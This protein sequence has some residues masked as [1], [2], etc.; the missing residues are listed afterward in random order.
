MFNSYPYTNFHEL[1][2]AYFLQQFAQIFQQWNELYTTLQEWKVTT[3]EELETWKDTQ[4]AAMADWETSLLADLATWK[5]TTEDDISAWETATLSALDDWKDAFQTLWDSTFSDLSDIKTDAE[6]ARDDAIAAQEAAEAA[7]LTLSGSV[8]DI[9]DLKTAV[10]YGSSSFTWYD[11]YL[12]RYD[13]GADSSNSGFSAAGYVEVTPGS[14]ITITTNIDGLGGI[15]QYDASKTFISGASLSANDAI[16]ENMYQFTANAQCHFIRFCTRL[17][18]KDSV[19]ISVDNMTVMNEIA[20]KVRGIDLTKYAALANSETTVI[21]NGTDYNNLTTPGTYRCGTGSAAATMTNA[22][23]SDRGHKLYVMHVGSH[24]WLLQIAIVNINTQVLIKA[25][26]RNDHNVWYPASGWTT[27]VS[28]AD[29]NSLITSVTRLNAKNADQI[30]LENQTYEGS[31]NNVEIDL[32]EY[33]TFNE[34]CIVSC[35]ASFTRTAGVTD[36]PRLRLA[37]NNNRDLER[38]STWYKIGKQGENEIKEWRVPAFNVFQNN[39]AKIVI[40]VPTGCTLTIRK[41]WYRYDSSI[42]RS[43]AAGAKFFARAGTCNFV[44]ELTLPALQMALRHGYDTITVIPKVSSDGVWFAYH[45]DTWNISTTNL[46]NANGTAITDTSY[47]GDYFNEIPFSYL[48]QFGYGS[49]GTMFNGTKV[50]TLEDCFKF[51]AKTGLKLRFSMHPYTG[52]NTSEKLAELRALVE[53]YGLLKDLTIIVNDIATLFTAFGNDI[54]GYCFSN[55]IGSTWDGST[56]RVDAALTNALAAKTTYNITTQISCGLWTDSLFTDA[57]KA[58]E[59]VRDILDE[60]FTA[61]AFVY[62]FVGTDGTTHAYL[63][64]EDME[65]LM[66]I[67]VTEFTDNYNTSCGLNW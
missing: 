65:W 48:Y 30:L 28:D 44:P 62:D 49:Y 63:W 25:R 34:T 46:R 3:T 4:E 31:A 18:Y 14:R 67:G 27:I 53:K 66:G 64:S 19:W 26:S 9:A 41:L 10:T 35:D 17:A 50:M 20:A 51:I 61:G 56:N 7:A 58:A 13:T 47:N 54:A 40:R 36:Y 24:L 43:P 22:P 38:Y 42:D 33:N 11:N 5:S 32:P 6:A 59:L 2:L 57:T 23:V 15:C 55:T 39:A 37:M 12:V 29:L 21:E 8:T 1:N 52:I 45:D 16:S 60:G